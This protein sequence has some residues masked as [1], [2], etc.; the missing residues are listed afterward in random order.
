MRHAG[1]RRERGNVGAGQDREAPG[2]VAEGARC[3]HLRAWQG[4]SVVGAGHG[5]HPTRH[6]RE[7]LTTGGVVP[8]GGI[9][10]DSSANDMTSRKTG[11][12]TAPPE[13]PKIG[14]SRTASTTSCGSSAGANPT[15]DAVYP[16]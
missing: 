8:V 1:D 4:E 16:R 3:H 9:F 11:A 14:L 10:S 2:E 13:W 7:S 6:G 12:A 5:A 15:N